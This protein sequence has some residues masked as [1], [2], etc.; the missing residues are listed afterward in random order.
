MECPF[1]RRKKSRKEVGKENGK[2][3]QRMKEKEGK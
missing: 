2:R 3:R 1:I